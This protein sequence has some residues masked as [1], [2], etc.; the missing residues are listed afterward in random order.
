MLAANAAT[1]PDFE[2][3]LLKNTFLTPFSESAL[4]SLEAMEPQR[5]CGCVIQLKLL[6]SRRLSHQLTSDY[7][8]RGK[9][10]LKACTT[11]SVK[12]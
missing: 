2:L 6:F 9:G 12:G 7:F 1:S 5:K 10:W 3:N 11:L 8:C 4:K